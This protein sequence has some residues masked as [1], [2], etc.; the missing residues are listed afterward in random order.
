MLA[1]RKAAIN[2]LLELVQF[3]KALA[4]HSACKT[5]VNILPSPMENFCFYS[6]LLTIHCKIL[7]LN[8]MCFITSKTLAYQGFFNCAL[9]S[10]ISISYR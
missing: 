2:Q 1:T 10:I 4:S 8:M 7:E 9:T 5:I 3:Q 6:C